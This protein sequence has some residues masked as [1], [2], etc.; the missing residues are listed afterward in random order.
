[1]ILERELHRCY[2]RASP[3]L[4][5]EAEPFKVVN[6]GERHREYWRPEEVRVLLLAESH[7]YTKGEECVPMKGPDQYG[8]EGV[9]DAFIRLVYC[10]GYGEREYAGLNLANNAGTWQYWKIFSSCAYRDGAPE[11]DLVLK[12]ISPI[13]MDRIS[14]KINLLRRLRQMGVWLVDSSV[15]A[16]YKPGGI[17]PDRAIRDRLLQ[18][19]WDEYIGHVVEAARPRQ[20]VVIGQGVSQAI[21]GRIKSITNRQPLTLGQP[22]G[23]RTR[24]QIADA[25][26]TYHRVCG[27]HCHGVQSR[28]V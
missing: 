26:E 5:E 16:L 22:Q 7:V 12:S 3:Y 14:A 27:E 8:P 20:V 15:L 19:C 25:Y 13:A 10:L 18:V 24:S 23:L 2:E 28:G 1:M 9:P 6:A 17:K 4:G 21:G 11:S